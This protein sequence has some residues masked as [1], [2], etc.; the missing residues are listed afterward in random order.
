MSWCEEQRLAWIR[1]CLDVFGFI[2]REH[3]RRKFLISEPQASKD[4]QNYA[5][6]FPGA[7]QYNV[8]TKR[9]E[10]RRR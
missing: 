5:R 2:N 9:Y 3:L 8:S 1:E 6:R 10:A 4:L 7:M